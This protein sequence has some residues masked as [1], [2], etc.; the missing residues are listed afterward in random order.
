[1]ILHK[2]GEEEE[3]EKGRRNNLLDDIACFVGDRLHISPNM[4]PVVPIRFG[5][6]DGG[7][8]QMVDEMIIGKEANKV[9]AV[10]FFSQ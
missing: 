10:S 8:L 3:H 6:L 7:L 9:G 5:I 1:M 2:D 4:G